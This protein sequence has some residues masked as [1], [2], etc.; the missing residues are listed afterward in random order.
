MCDDT[1]LLLD[2]MTA[3]HGVRS[4]ESLRSRA[5]WIELGGEKLLVADLSDIIRS[6]KA[7]GDSEIMPRSKRWKKPLAKS[8]KKKAQPSRREVLAAL[9]KESELAELDTI[10]RLLAKPPH[11]RTHFLRKRVGICATCL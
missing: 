4:F 7:A 10:H 3:A 11:E 5:A 6:K 8:G 2:F 9:R 1:A